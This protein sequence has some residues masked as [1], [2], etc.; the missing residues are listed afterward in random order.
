L[1]SDISRILAEHASLE[2]AATKL[3]LLIRSDRPVPEVFSRLSAFANELAEHLLNEHHILE[4]ASRRSHPKAFDALEEQLQFDFAAL[5]ADW[6][7]YLTGWSEQEARKDWDLFAEH[8]AV[9]I[10]R[11]RRRIQRE[12]L[13]LRTATSA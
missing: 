5:R 10:G 13:V 2:Q 12:N 1:D 6:D 4:E 8:T 3:E 9:M 11:V 7:E